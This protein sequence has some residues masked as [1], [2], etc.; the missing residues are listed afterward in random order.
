MAL[1]QDERGLLEAPCISLRR[2]VDPEACSIPEWIAV[3]KLPRVIPDN[4]GATS[5]GRI[6]SG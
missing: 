3:L 2:Q 1:S 5:M 6:V 4:F